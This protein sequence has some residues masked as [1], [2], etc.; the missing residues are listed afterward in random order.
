M[1]LKYNDMSELA[2]DVLYPYIR[3]YLM[4]FA[5]GKGGKVIALSGKD[6]VKEISNKG[7]KIKKFSNWLEATRKSK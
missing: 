4:A 2:E 6:K 1:K 7:V 3:A 5:L